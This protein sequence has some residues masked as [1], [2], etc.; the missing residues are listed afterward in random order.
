MLQKEPGIKF[1]AELECDNNIEHTTRT[2]LRDRLGELKR[3]TP[4]TLLI[5]EISCRQVENFIYT[6]Q[7]NNSSPLNIQQRRAHT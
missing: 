3:S 2:K 7:K 5:L 1:H 6:K 4:R